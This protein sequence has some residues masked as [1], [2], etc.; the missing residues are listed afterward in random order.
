MKKKILSTLLAGAAVATMGIMSAQAGHLDAISGAIQFNYNGLDA[1]QTG[2]DPFAAGVL[3]T[4][5]ASCNVASGTDNAPGSNQAN[6]TWGITTVS[7]IQD[8]VSPFP[9]NLWNNGDEGEALIAYFYGFNDI[10]V[11][12]DGAGSI[13][14][15][16]EGGY[17]DI[18]RVGALFGST[19]DM[20]DQATV[21][22]DLL[23]QSLYLRLEFV[24]GC[25]ATIAAAT[26]CGDFDLDSLSGNS[27]GLAMAIDGSAL[28]KFPEIFRFEQSVEPCNGCAPG[29]SFNIVVDSGSATTTALPEPGALGL[30]G[31]GLVGMGLIARR[32]KV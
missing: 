5:V 22:G 24:P 30:L 19:I 10:R 17:V 14:F 16:S 23:G 2:Y 28:S 3:C 27:D 32:R 20:T 25:S 1:A 6:D 18:Y 31:L 12:G 4:D 29:T 26:L 11:E 15:W 21:E 8:D 13:D 9:N 7:S